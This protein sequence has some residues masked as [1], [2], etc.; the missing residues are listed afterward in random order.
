MTVYNI[1]YNRQA[2][3]KAMFAQGFQNMLGGIMQGRQRERLGDFAEGMEPLDIS[4][5]I[6]A[7]AL[8]ANLPPQFALALGGLQQRGTQG[9]GVLPG[10]WNK[11]TPVQQQGYMDRVGGQ[12]INVFGNIPGYLQGETPE[13][14]KE[15][16]ERYRE[17][18]LEPKEDVPLTEPQVAGYGEAMDV[19]LDKAKRSWYK[20]KGRVNYPES[21]LF[22]Q[23]EIFAG[24][25]K[26]K[27]DTQ[28]EQIWNT[29]KNKVGNRGTAG[30]LGGKETDWDPTDPKWREAIGL[31]AEPSQAGALPPTNGMNDIEPTAARKQEEITAEEIAPIFEKAQKNGISRLDMYREMAKLKDLGL[32]KEEVLTVYDKLAEGATAEQLIEF[33]KSK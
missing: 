3:P 29:W 31:K 1:P 21:E 12:N 7:E 5:Q 30:W 14:T 28:K 10:W 20:Q 22:R 13:K 4:M 6:V 19:R 11:A 25:H 2:D 33:S 9:L 18:Q 16:V 27:N 26:F 17:K 24:I 23:W 32:T 8:K 15:N